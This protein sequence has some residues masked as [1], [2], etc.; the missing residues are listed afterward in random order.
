MLTGTLGIRLVLLVG[1]SVPTPA[2]AATTSLLDRVEVTNDARAG[3][4]F[5]LSFKLAKDS[6]RDF[7]LLSGGELDPLRRVVVGVIFGAA[8]EVLIDGVITHQQFVPSDEP[9]AS[10][11]T[12]T[13][14]DVS[15]ALDLE[16]RNEEYPNQPDSVIAARVIARHAKYGLA[17]QPT[18][19][20]DTPILLERIPRQHETDLRFLNRLAQRNGFVFYVEPV[21]FGVN[22][23]YF[24]PENRLGLPQ[25]ALTLGMG[26]SGNLRGISFSMDGLAPVGTKGSFVE[27][28]S[29]Q[30]IPIPALPSLKIPPLSVSP[31]PTLRT[32]LSRESAQAGAA[33]AA[34]AAVAAVTN[35]P[36]AITAQGEVDA[37]RYGHALRARRLVGVRGVGFS[38]DGAYFVNR[39]TH[40]IDR[41]SYRQRFTLSRE[42]TGSLLPAVPP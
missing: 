35:A 13:G 30:S 9:G 11:L 15:Q 37:T 18:A 16:E 41:G 39:V 3:D 5:Q 7:G 28:N 17:P 33:Q 14:R 24:G 6:L 29:K 27:A 32:V 1:D 2:P 26:P 4:G 8:P 42:G 19:T 23:A 21:T 38:Y 40:S 36:A 20:T 25:P 22:T 12:V 31:A 10:T 34:L